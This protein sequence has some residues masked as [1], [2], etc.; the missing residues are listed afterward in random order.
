MCNKTVTWLAFFKFLKNSSCGKILWCPR[1][2]N[3][4]QRCSFVSIFC[5]ITMFY[6]CVIHFLWAFYCFLNVVIIIIGTLV[7][8]WFLL[9]FFCNFCFLKGFCKFK[10]VVKSILEK[11]LKRIFSASSE[12]TYIQ[13]YFPEYFV[14]FHL[15][16]CLMRV[17][18]F[19]GDNTFK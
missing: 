2:S 11:N 4:I 3:W 18:Y 16:P 13:D 17:S 19:I 8:L 15:K 10:S 14:I 5:S 7:P 1:F 6:D 9:I 12:Y